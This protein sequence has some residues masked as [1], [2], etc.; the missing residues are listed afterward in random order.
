M[1]HHSVFLGSSQ[2]PLI[3]SETYFIDFGD[4][5]INEKKVRTITIQNDASV[6]IDYV[7]K[8]NPITYVTINPE[9]APV[10][11]ASKVD[12]EL[13]FQPL[14]NFHLKPNQHT[15]TL[16]VISGPTYHFKLSG[17]ARRPGVEFNF[18]SHDFGPCFV[19][20]TPMPKITT[21]LMKNMDNS[22]MS[23]ETLF[24]KKNYLDV[25]LANGQVL[26]PKEKQNPDINVISIPIIF[27]P[28][29]IKNYEQ[30]VTFDINN[31]H[32]IDVKI[33][34]EGIPMKLELE[35][36]EDNFVDFGI[37]RIGADVT[38]TISLVNYSK[39][40]ITIKLDV[41]NQLEELSKLCVSLYPEGAIVINPK[42]KHDIEI[43]F[44]PQ[45]RINA[46]KK[47][48]MYSV[49]END[50][51]NRLLYLQGSCHGMEL[52]LMDDSVTFGRIVVGSS[53]MRPLQL[54]N[55]GDIGAKFQWDTTFCQPYFSILP[56]KGFIPANDSTY[57]EVSFH[58][59][60]VDDYRFAIKCNV[61]NSTPMQLTLNGIGVEQS[62][63]AIQ[64]IIFE[65]TVRVA[66]SKKISIKNP[67]PK[68]WKIKAN[69][70]ATL[71]AW[72]GYFTGSD[73]LQ[74]PAN[75]TADYEVTYEPLSMTKN[76]TTTKINVEFHEAQLF[77][78]LPDGSAYSYVLKG[79]ANVPHPLKDE[80]ITIKAKS[81]HVQIITVR[82]WLKVK[83]RFNV[84]TQFEGDQPG[85]IVNGA[86][87]IDINEDNHK[88]FKLNIYA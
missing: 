51:T 60:V 61:E 68:P 71:P 17:T 2:A 49:C 67:T 81:D 39:R 47:E 70:S 33:I 41:G 37:Q 56:E 11:T 73:T 25:K 76:E 83:Q 15:F 26:L 6:P 58:P 84:V 24:E 88:D 53:V 55:L 74:V 3:S 72:R 66:F 50:E 57:F 75:G 82:N 54:N 36:A 9:T 78:P 46:F 86:N 34:G 85:I 43:R 5:Y 14:D 10:K 40:A 19:M 42:E 87:T 29:E 48:I 35:R 38:K 80:P 13:V 21:L 23:I 77:F 52:K 79:K 20:K 44:H 12:I 8:K 4:I 7:I 45:S 69:I 64:E 59:N 63:D 32:K 31:L 22:A 1:L 65:T 18:L 27:T 16:N 62:K 30:I 28:R